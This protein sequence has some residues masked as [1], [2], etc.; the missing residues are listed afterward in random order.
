MS[1]E[2]LVEIAIVAAAA[3]VC[4]LLLQR[5]RQ[6]VIVGYIA[7]GALLGPS[8]LELIKDREAVQVLAELGVLMLLFIIGMELSLRGFRRVLKIALLC[9][10]S[11]IAIGVSVMLAIGYLLG[12]RYELSVLFGFAIALS[13]T[14]VAIKILEDIGEIRTDIGRTA[15]SVLIAQDLAVV[16]MLLIVQGMAQ[17]GGIPLSAVLKVVLAVGLLVLLIL[18]LTRRER[19]KTPFTDRTWDNPEL[20]AV[21]AMAY[22]FCSALV[23]SALGLSAAYGAFLAGL[24]IGNS[25]A[26]A[27][28]LQA[29][30]PIQG[31]LLMVLFLSFGLL[32]DLAYI[33]DN[34]GTVLLLLMLVTVVKSVMNVALLKGFGEPWPKA[35]LAGVTIGQIGEFS[36]VLIAAGAA[37]GL[38]L[39]EDQRLAIAV[40]ALSL[41]I[42][43]FWFY[44]ARRLASMT[45]RSVRTFRQLMDALYGREA[46]AVATVSKQTVQFSIRMSEQGKDLLHHIHTG[47]Q[48]KTAAAKE[49]DRD[50]PFPEAASEETEDAAPKSNT[51][52]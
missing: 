52:D 47:D 34:I 48:D 40:I 22:C 13:S 11:Q 9:A 19:V 50:A 46:R 41:M 44:T 4:G 20:A 18:Y 32:L 51:G 39:P 3:L 43:P 16:P 8:G 30:I 6:P 49:D 10:G 1:G 5:L 37:A 17:G 24:W 23:S 2:G 15:I 33:W 38:L 36:F 7:A 45:W 26:R 21:T 35:W 42:S 29:A 31:V 14:A 28:I 12:W 25:T 27:P